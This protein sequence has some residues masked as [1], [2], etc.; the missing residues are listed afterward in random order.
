MQR[1]ISWRATATFL[2]LC[3]LAKSSF[4]GDPLKPYV[5]LIVDTSGSMIDNATG[6]GPPSCPGSVDTRLDHA[7][8]A[9]AGIAN[10][11]G[12][13]VFG[14]GRFRESST[15][16]NPANGC[17]MSGVDCNNCWNAGLTGPNCTAAL[18]SD[19]RLEV[20]TGM[21][22]GNNSDLVTWNDFTAGTCTSTNVALNPDIYAGGWTPIAGSLKGAKR[23][24]QGLQATDGT[25]LLASSQ[26]GF[27]PIRN[28]PLKDVFLPSGRQC[29]PYIVISLT[30]GEESCTQFSNTTAAAAS[31]LTTT[32]DARSYR[33]ETKAIGF[34]VTPGDAS[35]EGI[36]HA[37]G[38]PDVTGV[39]EGLYAA[40]EE[41]LQVAISSI[42]AE[43]V[44]FELCNDLD[45]DCDVLVDEDFPNKGAACDNGLV[46]RC[47][48]T[49]TYVC[50][51]GGAGTICSITSP[52]GTPSTETCNNIDDDCDNLIDEGLS[53]SCTG[54]EICNGLDDDCDNLIDE[55][56]TRGCGTDVGVCSTGTQVCT[57]GAWGACS[58]TG[59]QTEI[60]DGLDNDCDG[61]I[62]GQVRSCSVIVG[63][64]GVGVC[65]P[66]MQ[67]CT[68]AMWGSCIGEVGP[69]AEAC[70]T[71]DN[72]CDGTV[73]E[74][75]GGADCSSSCGVGQTVCMNGVLTCEG[76]V[77][78][79]PEIC[80]DFDD[81]CDGTVD[82]DVADMGPCT[83]APDGQPLC[84]PGVLRCVGGT[85]VCQGGEPAM[86]EICDCDDNDCDNQVDEGSLCGP[87][88][89]CTACQC[90][91]PCASGEFPCPEGRMCV[92]SFCLADPC[93]GV[94]CDPLPSGDQTVCDAG[95]CVRACDAVTC[96]AGEVCVGA[97]GQCRPD[98]C[99]TFPD[100]CSASEQCV[101]G[102]CV[103][104][105]CAGVTCG[106]DQYCQ[107]G[108][109][110]GTCTGVTCPTG[111]R[112]DRG[113][114]ETD[115]C[116]GPCPGNRICDETSGTCVNDPCLGQP[117]PVGQACNSQNGQCEQD[118]CL[119]VTCPNTGEVCANGTCFTPPPPI[120]AGPV[121]E[122][123]VTTGGGGG[124]QTSGDGGAGLGVLALA[125]TAIL[126]RRAPRTGGGR[127]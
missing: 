69:T 117:C 114:C 105:P 24:W 57:T 79:G 44:K 118:P 99:T 66:G 58:G 126:R 43:A 93:F 63:N 55:G 21:Y 113:M 65:H 122:D 111:E 98:N 102:T 8:C 64:P 124:C 73:D 2:T 74:G 104:D 31:L 6:F 33:I 14:L 46:G 45:D 56:L 112:C 52:G 81:D 5:F 77:G 84:M 101:A 23:Y 83:I 89:T 103:S 50:T 40:N 121:D 42:L 4:A 11:Y 37:G 41:Q 70:D 72:D 53:C 78:G 107:A 17:S 127:S 85:F 34:G 19:T 116:G 92:D 12:D 10:S 32:V 15:D 100:R 97:L 25:T 54:V 88:A 76:S 16:T 95:T 35:I 49:G 109:C 108:Q 120:D 60:C 94:T 71:I 27:D 82:E 123:R 9:I 90:A 18:W 62:D 51:A 115:P 61:V 47:R 22:D 30:D 48:G 125:L 36:A 106:S 38:A 3:L 110:V 20:L 29:R 68:A 26:P 91:L 7:K 67:T 39:N 86:T 1:V 96:A 87:G 28:D 75:T 119:G 13:M 80:N 59:P